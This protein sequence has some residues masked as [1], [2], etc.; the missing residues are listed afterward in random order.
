MTCELVTDPGF[1]GLFFGFWDGLIAIFR[2]VAS[3]FWHGTYVYDPCSHG[4]WYDLG[5]LLGV[6]TAAIFGIQS[7]T[8]FWWTFVVLLIVFLISLLLSTPVAVAVLLVVIV[9]WLIYNKK[10]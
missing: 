5:F 8:V 6:A 7:W 4:W 3:I 10:I 2:L 1:L 9:A